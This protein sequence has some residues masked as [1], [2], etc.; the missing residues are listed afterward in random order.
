M[1]RLSRPGI[2]ALVTLTVWA[3][4]WAAAIPSV[5]SPF[6][7]GNL[8]I[9]RVGD[10]VAPLSN[11]GSPVFLDEYRPDVGTLVQT[12][13]LPTAASGADH[14]LVAV[15]NSI[16]EGLLTRSSDGRF[17]FL[18]GYDASLGAANLL[19]SSAA[20]VPRVVGRVGA[21]AVIDTR[22]ALTDAADASSPRSAVSFEG[23]AFWFTGGTGGVRYALVGTTTSTQ[24][25]TL[26]NF[27]QI[28]VFGG[29]L[30]ASTGTT[31]SVGEVGTGLPI[32][33][34]QTL[35]VLV[36]SASPYGFFLADLNANEPGLD[37]LYVADDSTMGRI[38]K[39]QRVAGAWSALGSVSCAG[40]RGLTA[41]VSDPNSVALYATA[42]G[43]LRRFVDNFGPSGD[44]STGATA[45]LTNAPLNT[46]FRGVALAPIAPPPPSVPA[47]SREVLMLLV[48]LLAATCAWGLT[49][50]RRGSGS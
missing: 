5:A 39:Y 38:N 31:P 19:A 10:G 49:S 16:P 41:V 32:A 45:L 15:G 11:T 26:T 25:T 33:A 24:L 9:Y 42:S 47:A 17:L 12:I 28:Q 20:S 37:T 27:R 2:S 50:R 8:V 29:Q 36:S 40:C 1:E 48:V 21:D 13:P 3:V 46:A 6:T 34:G 35:T 22:T 7:P 23:N 30:Y 44:I 14:R 4:T 18:T 43:S